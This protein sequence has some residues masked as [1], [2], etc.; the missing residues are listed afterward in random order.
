[1]GKIT[2]GSLISIYAN[3]TCSGTPVDTV[4]A[5]RVIPKIDLYE[6]VSL[7]KDE[8]KYYSAKIGSSCSS[9]GTTTAKKAGYQYTGETIAQVDRLV[10]MSSATFKVQ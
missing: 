1:M 5:T 9:L 4:T 3:E 2:A 6:K 8:T 10:C 7:Q